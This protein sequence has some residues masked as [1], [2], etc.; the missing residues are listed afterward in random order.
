MHYVG[1]VAFALLLAVGQIL[2][3]VAAVKGADQP[4][5]WGL[6]NWWLV[7]A[8]A[9]YGVG[10]IIWVMVLRVMP[11]SHA[12][13]FAALGFVIVP[14]FAAA[15]FGEPITPTYLVGAAMIVGGIIVISW[16]A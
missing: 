5:P 9:I 12:Y 15:L 2:L 4:F 14:A 10:T 8:L 11:L 13:P 1:L 6:V 7:L 16:A 3:K